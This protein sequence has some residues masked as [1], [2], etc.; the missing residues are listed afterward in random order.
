MYWNLLLYGETILENLIRFDHKQLLNPDLYDYL[1]W[2]YEETVKNL[3]DYD[4]KLENQWQIDKF[5]TIFLFLVK[6]GKQEDQLY[7]LSSL[8]NKNK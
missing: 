1:K 4:L 7:V 6:F 2:V 8:K 3:N 5:Y